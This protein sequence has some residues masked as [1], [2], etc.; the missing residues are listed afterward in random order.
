MKN[1]FFLI[2]SLLII[3]I[4]ITAGVDMIVEHPL[5]SLGIVAGLL[6]GLKYTYPI[7]K[8]PGVFKNGIEVEIWNDYIAKNFF[9]TNPFLKYTKDRSGNVV[10][11]KIVHIE[12]AG[13]KPTVV[14]N[15]SGLP[16]SVT[17]R[18]DTDIFYM[19][20]EF[21]TDP[22]LVKHAEK[23]EL[24]YDKMDSLMGEHKEGLHETAGDDLLYIFSP[25]SANS[26]IR[27]T[28]ASVDTHITGT[29]GSRKAFTAKDLKAARTKLNKQGVPKTDR[30]AVM[31]EDMYDQFED[32]L[33]ANAQ[34]DFSRY[35]DAKEGVIGRLYGFDILTR[36]TV[37]TYNA[38]GTTPNPLGAAVNIDDQDAVLCW[39]KHQV[40]S[41]LGAVETFE[42]EDDATYYS[43]IISALMRAG[44]RKV[45]QD[46][47]GVIAIVQETA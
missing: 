38:A 32:S 26:I 16:A 9:K 2:M 4:T 20:N 43:T 18:V 36:P 3:S 41:A 22:V 1:R 15:R 42:N 17:Q 45:R 33:S 25:T 28:G 10:L 47:K 21:T 24:S 5:V 7:I 11:G 19:I 14:K 37:T 27:T 12:Q 44:G 13:A 31:S 39:Q 23:V 8:T 35:E 6:L 46:Q 29:T 34:K 40:E 30:V